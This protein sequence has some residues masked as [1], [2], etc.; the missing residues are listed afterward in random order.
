M[1]LLAVYRPEGCSTVVA[2]QP[3]V[4]QR[5]LLHVRTYCGFGMCDVYPV[6]VH[7]RFLRTYCFYLQNIKIDQESN[8]KD[9]AETFSLLLLLGIL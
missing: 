2:C 9:Q 8:G 7:R 5:L 6:A 3:A 4:P 1:L